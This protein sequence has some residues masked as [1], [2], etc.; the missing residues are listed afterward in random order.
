M[1]ENNRPTVRETISTHERIR[2]RSRRHRLFLL[3][4]VAGMA[5]VTV[6]IVN[7]R[8]QANE[9]RYQTRP[10]QQ[11]DITITVTA[12]GNLEATNQ[13]EVGSELSGIIREVLVDFNDTITVNQ[14][15]AALDDTKFKAAVRRSQAELNSA[16]AGLQEAIATRE[17]VE[18]QVE[19][20]RVTR[21]LTGGKLPSLESMEQAE[22]DLARSIAA[23][24]GAEAAIEVAQAA[25]DANQ[26]DLEKTVIYSPI[27]GIVLD[28]AIEPGQTVAASLQAP[29][30]FLLAEDLRAME[31]Q[32]DVD[33]A[34]IGRV[35][36][37]QQATFTVDAYPERS[38]TARI[39]QVRFGSQTTDGVVTYTTV[40]DVA[41]PKLLLRP[42]MTATAEIVVEKIENSLLVPNIA[43][44]F[45]PD[46]TDS[47]QQKRG[48][49]GSIFGGPPRTQKKSAQSTRPIQLGQQ[50]LW[51]VG[52]EGMAEP[53]VVTTIGTD[54]VM[55]AVVSG[56]LREDME[57]IVSRIKTNR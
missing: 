18:K 25:L 42:G 57:V 43:L 41:N 17:A 20:Y 21:E 6:L 10:V 37:G 28:R 36:E 39:S 3:V 26:T 11:G 15:L 13:V 32:V 38:F 31:L 51:I 9:I 52:P 8:Q 30:L 44:R 23:V 27:G 35:E 7:P 53:I 56:R 33:E 34:D 5:A 1:S 45:N 22:A 48:F 55:T 47:Q 50:N 40:L 46:E 14:P 24:S 54:D 2:R 29:V 4:L 19:R 49:L 16:R 12:T